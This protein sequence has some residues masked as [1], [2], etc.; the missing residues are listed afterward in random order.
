MNKLILG[1]CLE[2]LKKIETETIDLVYIDPPFFSNRNYEIVWGDKGE[3]RSF[4]DRWSGGV[5]QYISWLKERV[6]E[7]YRLLKPT[8]SIFLHC[9]WHASHYIKA[10]VLDKLFGYDNFRGEIAW[11]RHNAHNDAKKKLAVLKDS[12]F[13]YTK[14]G[15]FSYNPIYIGL[16]DE[17]KNNFYRY[18][19]EKGIFRLS[20]LTAPNI[21]KNDKEWRGFHPQ[22]SNRHWAIPTSAIFDIVGEAQAKELTTI[23][24]LDLLFE[25]DLIQV[26]KTGI[27]SFKRYLDN[28]KGALLGDIWTDIKN[29]QSQAKEKIGYPTQKPEALLER[30]IK[31][32]SNEGDTVLDC[33]MGGGTTIAVA[34]KLKR[35]WIGIDQSEQAYKVTKLRLQKNN[36]IFE[37]IQ[38]EI[39]QTL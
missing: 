17:Y 34:D 21:N 11:Q 38:E 32:A 37:M 39:I 5:D 2:V 16:S 18:E 6:Q 33:F 31:M 23:E 29:V 22:K 7:M 26:S 8:G 28:S 4:K 35:N 10:Y 1:D 36:A 12:I 25:N 30:I 14:N 27:P 15:T 9:D 20:D 19:D 24:K 13:Y 3:I